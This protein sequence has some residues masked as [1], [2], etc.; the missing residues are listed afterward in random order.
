MISIPNL[1]SV[2]FLLLSTE[3]FDF[4]YDGG[5]KGLALE[6]HPKSSKEKIEAFGCNFTI[7]ETK[8]SEYPLKSYKKMKDL[9]KLG[10]LKPCMKYEVTLKIQNLKN[11]KYFEYQNFVYTKIEPSQVKLKLSLSQSNESSATLKWNFDNTESSCFEDLSIV[12]KNKSND[13]LLVDINAKDKVATATNLSPCDAYTAEMRAIS[14]RNET[15]NSNVLTFALKH[16]KANDENGPKVVKISVQEFTTDSIKVSWTSDASASCLKEHQILV[17]DNKMN[18]MSEQNVFAQSAI[19]GNLSQCTNYSLHLIDRDMTILAERSLTTPVA[20]P[21]DDV[22]VVVDNLKAEVSWPKIASRDCLLNFNVTYKTEFCDEE[23]RCSAKTAIVDK[24]NN[25]LKISSLP[26]S[27]QFQWTFQVNE[28]T[29]DID[30]G[31]RVSQMKEL[32]FDTLDRDAFRVSNV[33]EFRNAIDELQLS[34]S[35][36]PSMTKFLSHYKVTIDGREHLTNK[37]SFGFKIAACKTNYSVT[38]QCVGRDFAGNKSSNC[39]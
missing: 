3:L 28:V 31:A 2:V 13:T 23:D 39:V 15:V 33:Q 18:L 17:Y 21:L 19:I 4:K 35:L 27:E 37:T 6:I 5:S 29:Y 20:F 9:K 34:W 7:R 12:L 25:M 11:N 8:I 24:E 32:I 16:D 36:D 38:I 30:F 10:N 1:S 22:K 14:A 26:P